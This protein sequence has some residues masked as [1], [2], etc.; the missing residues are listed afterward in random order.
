MYYLNSNKADYAI[1]LPTTLNEITPELLVQLTKNVKVAEHYRI[2]CLIAKT[3]L[4]KLASGV[5]GHNGDEIINVVP[6]LVPVKSELINSPVNEHQL[7]RPIIAP[8][9]LER[10]Y[11]LFIPTAA[12][13]QAVCGYIQKDNDL[14]VALFQK[15]YTD[16]LNN[17]TTKAF[18]D[19]DIILDNNS[20]I[21]MLGFKIVAE[22]DIVA[23]VPFNHKVDDPAYMPKADRIVDTH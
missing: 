10:G 1:K 14:R 22:N 15:K 3:T 21:Y 4:F 2:V 6:A 19:K 11:E 20:S 5:N 16:N 9:V 7:I 17:K 13:M 8:S 23:T 12:S 18:D